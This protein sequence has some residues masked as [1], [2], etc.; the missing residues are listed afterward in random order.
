VSEER[1]QLIESVVRD[2]TGDI[3]ARATVRWRL[4]PAGA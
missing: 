4:A 3:V 2:E 1:E